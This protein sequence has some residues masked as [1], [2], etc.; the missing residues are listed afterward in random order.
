MSLPLDIPP[1]VADALGYLQYHLQELT[2]QQNISEHTINTTLVGLTAQLQQFTQLMTSPTPTL[3]I[4][5]PPAPAPSPPVSPPSLVSDALSKQQARLKLPFSPDFSSEQ[6]F[7]QAFLNSYML[8]LCLAP[9]QFS[10]NEEKI[11]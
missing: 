8:Y 10:Y 2:K 1:G 7:G 6:S 5:P 3:T 9:E 11:F 4:A